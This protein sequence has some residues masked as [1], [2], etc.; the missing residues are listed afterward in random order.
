MYLN[1]LTSHVGLMLVQ[2]TS[3]LTRR[4]ALGSFGALALGAA[5][6]GGSRLTSAQ[7]PD[8]RP[9]S[10]SEL[11]QRR[12][13]RSPVVGSG[14]VWKGYAADAAN[15]RAEPTTESEITREL[16]AGD[17]VV[18]PI[19]VAGEEVNPD[20]PVWAELE[21]GQFVY[22]PL[23]RSFPVEEPPPISQ[24]APREGRWIDVNLTLEI[25]T[26]YEGRTPVA[27]Y[28]GSTGQPGWE[29]PP[30]VHAIIRRVESERMVGPDYD[31]PNVL[32]TQY[33]T[34]EGHA[35]HG[36]YW[37]DPE[38]FGMPGSHGCVSLLDDQALELWQF[39]DIGTPLLIHR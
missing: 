12:P 6:S 39:A 29:T 17:G 35:L 33:F 21:P 37:R 28:L 4:A 36:N 38:L 1:G 31:V 3:G 15:V 2:R 10:L 20:Y 5:I 26:A 27:T 16:A 30:G 13:A 22:L 14:L 23:L 11:N 34:N 24:V 25:V 8:T 9:Q 19:W 32:W 18:V 7:Q